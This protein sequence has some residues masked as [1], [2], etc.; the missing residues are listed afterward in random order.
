MRKALALSTTILLLTGCANSNELYWGWHCEGDPR[1]GEWDCEQR[2]MRDGQLVDASEL[3][4]DQIP[5]RPADSQPLLPEAQA[6]NIDGTGESVQEETVPSLTV[7]PVMVESWR[8]QLPQLNQ[9]QDKPKVQDRPRVRISDITSPPPDPE[10]YES[11]QLQ[12]TKVP[13]LTQEKLLPDS[14]SG[15]TSSGFTL[16]LAAL[17]N[18]SAVEKFIAENG[19]QKSTLESHLIYSNGRPWFAVTAGHFPDRESAEQRGLALQQQHPGI[20]YWI[21]SMASLQKAKSPD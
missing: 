8:E 14:S 7:T 15:F 10:P 16:Q 9:T 13:V 5:P 2:L 11:L 12:P 21:R 18:E 6:A 17:A 3:A 19:L 20:D 4:A 1:T